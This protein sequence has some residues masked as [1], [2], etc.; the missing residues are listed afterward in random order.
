MDNKLFW[1]VSEVLVNLLEVVM[2]QWYLHMKLRSGRER[3]PALAG[4]GA[5][6]LALLTVCNFAKTDDAIRLPLVAT[7]WVGYT[8]VLYRGQ[9]GRRVFQPLLVFIL[10]GVSDLLAIGL[11]TFIP[12]VTFD[13]MTQPTV[14]RL[15]G[16]VATKLLFIAILFFLVNTVKKRDKGFDNRP[17][18]LLFLVVPAISAAMLAALIQYELRLNETGAALMLLTTVGILVIN[19]IVLILLQVLSENTKKVLAQEMQLQQNEIQEKYFSEIK[20]TNDSLRGFRHDLNNHLQV[21]DGYLN[22]GKYDKAK[23]YLEEIGEFISLTENVTNTGHSLLDAVIGAKI[24]YARRLGIKASLMLQVPHEL[25]L[26]Q[27]ELCTVLGNILDNAIE[28]CERIPDPAVP[29]ELSLSIDLFAG[30][31]RILLRNCALLPDNVDLANLT[32]SKN[33]SGH[34]IGISNMRRVVDGHDGSV[35]MSYSDNQFSVLILLPVQH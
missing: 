33:E 12:G 21:L 31:L 14:Y 6:M 2:T 32:T 34:G 29:K 30:H 8:M 35:H 23:D 1:D 11:L 4:G 24:T 27:L 15:Q 28:A 20:S 16:M 13:L 19:L 25:P 26:T 17:M 7:C 3:L 22:L 5:L 10:L 18:W 9:I